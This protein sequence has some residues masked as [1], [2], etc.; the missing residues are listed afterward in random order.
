MS[1]SKIS[2]QLPPALERH[3]GNRPVDCCVSLLSFGRFYL[4][5]QLLFASGASNAG[6]SIQSCAYRYLG[7]AAHLSQSHHPYGSRL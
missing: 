7:L 3:C 6:V 1:V 4:A 5:D 2:G